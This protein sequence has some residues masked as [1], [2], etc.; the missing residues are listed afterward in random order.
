MQCGFHKD[1]EHT[2]FCLDCEIP[3]CGLCVYRVDRQSFCVQCASPRIERRARV[4]KLLLAIGLPLLTGLLFLFVED[5]HQLN[6]ERMRY[7]EQASEVLRFRSILQE[8]PCNQ[9]ASE[10]LVYHLTEAMNFKEARDTANHYTKTCAPNA[11]SLTTLFFTERQMGDHPASLDT[12]ERLIRN[13]PHKPEGFAYRGLAYQSLGRYES[14]AV[15]FSAALSLNPRLLDVPMNLAHT[16]ELLGRPCLAKEPLLQA[17]TFYPGLENRFE[18]ELRIRRLEREGDCPTA[19]VASKGAEVPF[20]RNREIMVLNAEVNG[21]FPARLILDTGASSVVVSRELAERIGVS[22]ELKTSPVYVQ[23]AGGIV[24]AYPTRLERLAV[25]G[26]VVEDLP[27]LVCETFGKDYDGLLGVN[28]LQRFKVTIDPTNGQIH[29]RDA[30]G[31]P[32]DPIEQ[33]N[34]PSRK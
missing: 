12:A 29:F 8:E 34:L 33:L 21:Q 32:A 6:Q 30:S 2:D 14:A 5:Q 27:V 11:Q 13:F 24:D 4:R 15:D 23:T 1:R 7:G 9:P 18:L 25:G 3:L 19:S 17:L 20:D 22:Q 31:L 16:L 26:A 28:F 10:R